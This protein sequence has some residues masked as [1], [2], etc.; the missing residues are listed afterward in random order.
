MNVFK[1]SAKQTSGYYVRNVQVGYLSPQFG[2]T[3]ELIDRLELPNIRVSDVPIYRV[4]K[5]LTEY[6][7]QHKEDIQETS[8]RIASTPLGLFR[9]FLLWETRD[10]LFYFCLGAFAILT[11]TGHAVIA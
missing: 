6:F 2:S 4:N 10:V 7:H 1:K 11:L 5:L 9:E 8:P 3:L